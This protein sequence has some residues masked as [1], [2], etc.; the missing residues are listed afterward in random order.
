VCWKSLSISNVI[1]SIPIS[2]GWLTLIW[3]CLSV[4]RS[5]FIIYKKKNSKSWW[6]WRG[7]L[8]HREFGNTT[9]TLTSHNAFLIH[10]HIYLKHTPMPYNSLRACIFLFLSSVF[11]L[12]SVLCSWITPIYIFRRSNMLALLITYLLIWYSCNKH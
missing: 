6:T 2:L 3:P 4:I 12:L 11:C 1:C 8:D 7:F 9:R 10:V 5:I